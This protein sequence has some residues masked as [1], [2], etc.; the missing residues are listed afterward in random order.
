MKMKRMILM[1]NPWEEIS[2]PAHDVFSRRVDHTH[3]LNLFWARDPYG[4]FLFIYEFISPDSIPDKFPLLNG[5]E[6]RLLTPEQHQSNN[7]ML[8]L[9]LKDKKDWQIFSSLCNDIIASTREID[10]NSQAT[11]IILRRLKRWQEFL[12]KSR[13]ELLSEKEIKGLIG[14]LLF[15]VKHLAPSFGMGQAIQFWQGPEDTPQ[16]FNIENCAVE[17]KCQLGT[18]SPAVHISSAEQLCTQLSKMYLYVVTLGKADADA[19][20]VVN[21]PTLIRQ[22][23]HELEAATPSALERFNNLIYQT[24]YIDLDEYNEYSY[25]LSTEQMFSVEPGFPRICPSDL[26]PGIDRLTYDINL[27]D[28]EPFTATPDWMQIA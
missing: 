21:L 14:E 20:N 18:T 23:R 10:K 1:N 12:Q 25:L 3:P 27:L 19:E 4:R 2:I 9:I 24:G 11:R 6:V 15:I 7:Y 16:D 5:I 22:I 28:C 13:S 26:V 17:V 8:L